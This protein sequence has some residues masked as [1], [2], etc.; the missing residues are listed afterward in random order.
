MVE[1][2]IYK[3]LPLPFAYRVGPTFSAPRII[4]GDSF[5]GIP[6][7]PLILHDTLPRHLVQIGPEYLN[8]EDFPT[9]NC[10]AVTKAVP[11][12]IVGSG[13]RVMHNGGRNYPAARL[14]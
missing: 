10:R 3:L 7:L 8:Y 5:D 2:D 4:L 6:V 9:S 1:R 13:V 12:P 14:C 11:M